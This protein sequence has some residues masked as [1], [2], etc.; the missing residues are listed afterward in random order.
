MDRII[1][2][3][4]SLTQ[5]NPP[6]PCRDFAH[7]STT[8]SSALPFITLQNTNHELLSCL[9]PLIHNILQVIRYRRCHRV[10][11]MSRRMRRKQLQALQELREVEPCRGQTENPASSGCS[12]TRSV[13]R[14]ANVRFRMP[15]CS[16]VAIR[17]PPLHRI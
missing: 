7:H 12:K 1:D 16:Y 17:I 15:C 13:H 14:H 5:S 10:L 9:L 8:L 6:I 2:L 11:T 3:V 4:V